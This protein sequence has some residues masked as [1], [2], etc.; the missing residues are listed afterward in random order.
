MPDHASTAAELREPF[1]AYSGAVKTLSSAMPDIYAALERPGGIND[2]PGWR[3]MQMRFQAFQDQG[4]EPIQVAMLFGPSGAG[5]STVFRQLTGIDVPAGGEIRPMTFGCAVA[6][7]RNLATS[8]R[9]EKLFPFYQLAELSSPDQLA[10]K[11]QPT[12]LLYFAESDRVP[13]SGE[14]PLVLADVPDFTTFFTENWAKAERMLERAEIVIFV[15]FDEAYSDNRVIENLALACRKASFLAYLFTKTN[16][17]AAEKKWQHLLQV[18]ESSQSA[19]QFA[20]KRVDGR[21]VKE[22]LAA[23]PVYSSARSETP[24]LADITPVTQNTPP[25][26]SLMVGQDAERIILS[27]LLE[28]T[29]QSV[30]SC[31][32]LLGEARRR[33]SDLQSLL[34]STRQQVSRAAAT[35]ARGEFPVLRLLAIAV[36]ESQ[37]AEVG[38]LRTV[39][40]PMRW[41]LRSASSIYASAK[42]MI[43]A[44]QQKP[45]GDKSV[46]AL[47]ELE[48]EGIARQCEQL[49]TQWRL[50]FPLEATS[51]G[52]LSATVCDAVHKQL[53]TVVPP[54]PATHWEGVIRQAVR[55]WCQEHRAKALAL[56]ACGDMFVVAAG[57]IVVLD[58]VHTGGLGIGS[59]SILAGAPATAFA[60]AKLI[61]LLNLRGVAE[62]ALAEWQLQR[63]AE[64]SAHLQKHFADPL[65][66][67]WINRLLALDLNKI[68]ACSIA[69]RDVDQLLKRLRQKA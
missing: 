19:S 26:E 42:T 17:G 30:K 4:G 13:Q 6:A 22:F 12:D 56:S 36:E 57:S 9:L 33:A 61:E 67:R 69:C 64:L 60:V 44:F 2:L 41:L 10:D 31:E 38:W 5:K 18:V 43:Q 28:S 66:Q 45:S 49:A 50:Q 1:S 35:I 34:D 53:L 63:Q 32:K 51:D 14:L 68:N 52:M 65:F 48:R 59:A 55:T 24:Q 3:S 23:A 16:Q 37:A 29:S 11:N 62:R 8:A 47:T 21:T 27:G 7:P 54:E 40:A 46:R 58:L 39:K 20:E 25:F 15:V